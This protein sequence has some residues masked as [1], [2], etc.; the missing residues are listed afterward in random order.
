MGHRGRE[1][2]PE[3]GPGEKGAPCI[4]G[5]GFHFWD[6]VTWCGSTKGGWY[7]FKL[8]QVVL[9]SFSGLDRGPIGLSRGALA[10]KAGGAL[11]RCLFLPLIGP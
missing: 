11:N 3:H 10:D 6:K 5:W 4:Y 8:G 7:S 2:D 1:N 9:E